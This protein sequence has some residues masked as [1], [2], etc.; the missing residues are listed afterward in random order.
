MHYYQ[1]HIGD[2]L[3]HTANLN[4]L[5]HGVYLRLLH[6]YYMGEGPLVGDVYRMIGARS[7][8]EK[9]AVDYVLETFFVHGPDGYSQA[10]ADKRI[11]Q[12]RSKSE[13]ARKAVEVRWKN[14]RNTDVDTNASEMDTDVSEK[15]TDA[16]LTNNHKPITNTKPKDKPNAPAKAVAVL[17]PKQTPLDL[18]MSV[19]GMTEQ[20]AKDH[21][22]VRKA[23]KS[24]LTETAL[25]LIA[26]EADKAGITTAQAVAI[27]TA[28]GW[29]SFKADWIR[30]DDNKKTHVERTQDFKDQQAARA[31][32]PLLNASQETLAKWGLVGND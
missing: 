32:A 31:Y 9:Q 10:G 8:E 23:K 1:H 29:V 15:D 22:A 18:L 19:S 28:R 11:E 17:V 14:E 6:C 4:L 3:S 2:Y 25:A 27:S 12:F 5:E 7:P 26:K 30:P 16:I 13:K 21:L 24:P 20:V